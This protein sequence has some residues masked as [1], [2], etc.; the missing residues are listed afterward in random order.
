MGLFDRMDAR[1]QRVVERQNQQEH[2]RLAELKKSCFKV[3]SPD[4]RTLTILAQPSGHP[5]RFVEGGA[6]W[7]DI[8][9]LPTMRLIALLRNRYQYHGGWT[10]AV[11]KEGRWGKIQTKERLPSKDAAQVRA[12]D[13]AVQMGWTEDV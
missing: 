13:V 3:S 9:I 6:D 2:E 10:V 11:I 8:V 4:G 12:R 5:F 7:L 1:N